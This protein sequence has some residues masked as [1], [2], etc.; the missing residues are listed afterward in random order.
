VLE[1]YPSRLHRH[2]FGLNCFV[3][4]G[5]LPD[6]P[7]AEIFRGAWPYVITG[8]ISIY[9]LLIFQKIATFLPSL[10]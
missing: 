8:V 5:L 9:I 1:F 3:V 2:R 4:K 10:M 6:M 7:L